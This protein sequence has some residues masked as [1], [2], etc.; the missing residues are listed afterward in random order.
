MFK[1]DF[2]C[3]Q[4]KL[5]HHRSH[6]NVLDSGWH[7]T[8]PDGLCQLVFVLAWLQS[9]GRLG[10]LEDMVRA[11]VAHALSVVGQAC[12]A[13]MEGNVP[14]LLSLRMQCGGHH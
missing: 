10:S 8:R 13:C 11:V 4:A 5:K 12:V 3:N 6:V 2:P 1:R 7:K 9:N 14:L